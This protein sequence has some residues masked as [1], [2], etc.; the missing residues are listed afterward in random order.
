MHQVP[1]EDQRGGSVEGQGDHEGVPGVLAD[2]HAC[3][4]K[5]N[6]LFPFLRQ[7][8]GMVAEDGSM[9]YA[10]RLDRLRACGNGVVPLAAAYAFVSLW[11]CLEE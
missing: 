7:Q 8:G 6:A 1:R 3:Q 9:I 4:A 10:S 5:T 2:I 11:A